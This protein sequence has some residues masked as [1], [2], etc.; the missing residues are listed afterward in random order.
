MMYINN[1]LYALMCII[2]N[3]YTIC[4]DIFIYLYIFKYIYIH[5]IVNY[6]L[7]QNSLNNLEHIATVIIRN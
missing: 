3:T 2:I 4:I 7:I 1:I 5:L 6:F